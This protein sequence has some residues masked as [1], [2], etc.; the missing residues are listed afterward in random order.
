MPFYLFSDDPDT[1]TRPRPA[2]AGHECLV[3]RSPDGPWE[4]P[5]DGTHP[6]EWV[7]CHHPG[8]SRH[9]ESGGA[10]LQ[11]GAWSRSR[12]KHDLHDESHRLFIGLNQIEIHRRQFARFEQIRFV[13]PEV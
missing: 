7:Q 10:V 3:D 4:G 1:L 5:S 2:L 12:F 6:V 8:D 11:G 9:R 13:G